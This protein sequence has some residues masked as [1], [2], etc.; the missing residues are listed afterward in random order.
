MTRSISV[1][2]PV[3][4][5]GPILPVL[6][7]RLS[8]VLSALTDVWEVILVDDASNDGTFDSVLELHRR[9][10]RVKAIRFARNMGQHYATLHG[11]RRC[12]GEYVL[13]LD[14]DLQNPPEEIP[15]FL[16]R[17]DEGYDLVIGRIEGSKQHSLLRNLASGAVQWL[18]ARILGKPRSLALSSYRCMS[19]RAARSIS[20]YS[21]AQVYLP[22]LM[23]G[24]VPTDR[25]CNI[26]VPHHPRMDGHSQYTL[27]KL[28]KLSSYLVINHSSIPLRF[29]TAWGTF[30]CVASLVYAAYVVVDVLLNGSAVTGW[31]T[32][33][34]LV[35]F[36]SGNVLMCMGIL[37]EYI[38]RLVSESA[39]SGQSPVFEEHL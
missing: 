17:V 32:L 21:G 31:P 11:L 25:I 12:M 1:V 15:R 37:G 9:D 35:S 28:L 39:R 10:S 24:A 26:D 14:D 30:L 4:R 8:T 20:T 38:G 18:I 2:V 22:A 5:S 29:V 33:A 34:V 19:R 36:M 27:R 23:L 7:E 3:Y 13:T 6:Y 16:T